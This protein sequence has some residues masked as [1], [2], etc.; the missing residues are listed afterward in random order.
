M[1]LALLKASMEYG[2]KENLGENHRKGDFIFY[3]EASIINLIIV[4]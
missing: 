2:G 4:E 3:P 1:K